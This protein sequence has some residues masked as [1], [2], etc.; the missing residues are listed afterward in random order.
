MPKFMKVATTDEVEDQQAK[1]VEVE[2]QRIALFRE[3]RS[4]RRLNRPR[5]GRGDAQIHE[6]GHER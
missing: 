2:G 4:G 3:G 5:G 1:L 6:G